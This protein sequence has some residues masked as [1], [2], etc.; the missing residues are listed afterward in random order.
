M[1]GNMNIHSKKYQP[2]YTEV[3]EEFRERILEKE[4]E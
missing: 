1:D 3:G 4:G 2:S